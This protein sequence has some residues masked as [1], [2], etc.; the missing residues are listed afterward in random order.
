MEELMKDTIDKVERI[1]LNVVVVMSDLGSNF[2]SLAKHLKVIP[3]R[4]WFMHN[5]KKYYLMFDP[6]HLIKCIRNNLMKYTFKFGQYTA[7]WQDIVVFYNKDKELPIRAAPKLTDKHI[8]PNNFAKMKVKY[9][10][11]ILSHTVTASICM[12]VSVGGLP[13]SAM[14]TA[15]C[16]SKFDSL[17]DSVNVSTI[18]SQKSLKCALTQ[19]SPHLSFFEQAISFI[20]SIKIF[21]GD[22]EVTGRIKCL[23]GCSFLNSSRGN[24]N[25]DFDN[26]LAQFSKADSS[27]PVLV[28]ASTSQQSDD[29]DTTDYKEK[30]VSDNLL[31][32]N[33]IA[34][35]AGYLLRK[36]FPKHKCSTCESALVTDQ[37]EDNRNLLCFFKAYE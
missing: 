4:P 14:G 32:N 2:Q 37:L 30:E 21:Q 15:E 10:T 19:T 12:Y 35:V 8:R 17:F 7:K 9:A 5:Q 11:Q 3:E 28:A 23:N 29:I 31:K 13:S 34:Y 6:P 27:V 16:I 1:G 20:K 25:D 22:E 33:P 26:L 36:S 24:C 18:H